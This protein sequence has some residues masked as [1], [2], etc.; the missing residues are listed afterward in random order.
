MGGDSFYIMIDLFVTA[1]G[2][3]IIAQYLFMV[4]TKELRQNMLIPKETRVEHCKD[5]QGYIQTMAT[6]QLVFG[7]ATTVCGAITLVQDLMGDYNLYV[8]MAA[9]VIFLVLCIWYGRASK[10]AIE[11]FW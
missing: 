3:Y 2:I 7:I 8:S 5:V 1:C 10:K 6:K 9:M 4:R 11:K